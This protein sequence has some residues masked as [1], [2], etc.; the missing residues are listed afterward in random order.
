VPFRVRN[1]L[2]PV[3]TVLLPLAPLLLTT[4]S[5]EELFDRLLNM[6]L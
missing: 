6:V 5:A 4:F 3:L 2:L 1:L